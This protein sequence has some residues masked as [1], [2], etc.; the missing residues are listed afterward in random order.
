MAKVRAI[1]HLSDPRA[2]GV[3]LG[4][5]HARKKA[6]E[7]GKDETFKLTKDAAWAKK[8]FSLM[9][10]TFCRLRQASLRA[11]AR[12]AQEAYRTD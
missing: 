7:K 3:R 8:H 1:L 11:V 6:K 5:G 4:R 2:T 10:L 12:P 9:R